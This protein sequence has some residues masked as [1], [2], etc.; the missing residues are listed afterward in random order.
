MGVLRLTGFTGAWPQRDPKAL[1]ENA[2]AVATNI[3]VDG[4]AYLKGLRGY[5]LIKALA[6]ATKA[7]YRIP[8]PG[9]DTF[10]NSFWMEFAD[11]NTDVVPAPIVNDSYSR[12]YWASPSTG[13]KYAPKA[14]IIAAGATYVSGVTPPATMPVV[15]VV[16]GTGTGDVKETRSYTVTFIDIYGQESQPGPTNEATGLANATFAITS[17]PQPVADATRA[18]IQTIRLYRTVTAVG[19]YTTFYKVVDL[20]VGTTF[21]ND[22]IASVT[23][24]GQT[25]LESSLWNAPPVMDGIAA[26]PNGIFVGFKDRNVYFSENYRPHA[27]P[28][29]YAIQ[30][31][32]EVVGLGVFGSSCVIVT[33]G[34]PAVVTGI[35]SN[36]MALSKVDAPMPCLSRRS[37][38]AAPEGVYWA[39]EEGI[40]FVGPGGS[41]IATRDLIARKDWGEKYAP[42]EMKS[43]IVAGV[44]TGFFDEADDGFS[45]MPMKP[46]TRG[47]SRVSVPFTVK[48]TGTDYYSGK[49][50]IIGSDNNLY[51]WEKPDATPLTYTWQSK[52]FQY[53]KPTNF[54]AIQAFFDG[55]PA[56][57]LTVKVYVTL[58][59][60][61]GTLSRQLVYNQPLAVSGD[62]YRL[63]AG[64][65]SDLWELEFSGA[66]ELQE[67]L[68]ASSVQEL[69]SA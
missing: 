4:G 32:Y 40:A 21:Y 66:T 33:K 59:G 46:E 69:R 14:N 24:T 64:F 36:A 57:P 38:V 19:G 43:H 56:A 28:A 15:N 60:N 25:Q 10:A 50:W 48:N 3:R 23:V 6:S 1:P 2:A 18:P 61:D 31:D 67:F 13:L 41:T 34:K 58:R 22:S 47:V 30:V 52:P 16:G 55:T 44:Y 9:A 27:W 26:M 51:E 12:I 7:V 54:S 49:P 17:I 42:S 35:K 37:I 5:S 20:A 8:L 11:E 53:P 62:I 68:M 29:E 65:K 45:F 39:T 63:P